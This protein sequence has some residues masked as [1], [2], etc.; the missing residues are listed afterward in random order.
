MKI[1]LITTIDT[2]IGDDFIREGI[3]H[4]LQEIFKGEAIE[5]VSI[6][7]HHPY[8]VYGPW[9]PVHLRQLADHLP[10]GA[11]HARRAIESLF[12]HIRS[13]YFDSC[14]LIVQCGA[15][16]FWPNCS[17]NE[18]AVPLWREVV[19]RLSSRIP[20][21]N[22]AA[23]SCYPWGQQPRTLEPAADA[24]YVKSILG[25][26][27]LTTVRDTL[28]KSLCESVAGEV[29]LLPC[30]ALLAPY[31]R[32]AQSG[33]YILINYMAGGGHDFGWELGIDPLQWETT[34]K[35]LID[36]LGKRH[37]VAFLCHDQKEFSLSR[38]IAPDLPSFFPT[39][40]AEYF[41]C[42]SKAKFAICN[43]MHASVGMAGMGI[44]SIAIGRDT[45]LLMVA[46]LGL[47][48]H[49][50]SDVS[51]DLLHQET[52]RM[53]DSLDS[54]KERLLTLQTVTRQGYLSF[55]SEALSRA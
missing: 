38:S 9:H 1:G 20:V 13:T 36:L 22:L 12:V 40:P 19:A 41:D 43:R 8:S 49:Y 42:V 4:L 51:A 33:E 48:A 17:G 35:Q 44:P 25:Y 54:E 50:V 14:D 24:E 52:E 7:K 30:S 16:V 47:P 45:R 23:G 28:A 21:L 3:C 2:N 27:R 15:P 6:N 46:Q 18:W 10:V 31:G 11:N 34:V 5:Y 29:Q 32:I 39:T 53:L 55:I 37:K 26:C